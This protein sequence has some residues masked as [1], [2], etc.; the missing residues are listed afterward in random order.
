MTGLYNRA[1]RIARALAF[2]ATGFLSACEVERA[3]DGITCDKLRALKAGMPIETVRSLL[4]P[5]PAVHVK[6]AQN[7]IGGPTGAD[8]L[9]MWLSDSNGVR[10]QLFFG[11]GRLLEVN[12]YIRTTWRDLFDNDRRPSLFTLGSDGRVHEGQDF[13]RVYCP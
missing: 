6:D 8:T 2:L 7:V 3:L 10:L 11:R 1:V 9:W 13:K 12:S 4:P 5:P